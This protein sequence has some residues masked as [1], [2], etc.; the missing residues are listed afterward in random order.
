MRVGVN[1][2][3]RLTGSD[4]RPMVALT[5]RPLVG[6]DFLYQSAE[7]APLEFTAASTAD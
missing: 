6:R 1:I 2:E 3:L 7:P 4:Y 5:A